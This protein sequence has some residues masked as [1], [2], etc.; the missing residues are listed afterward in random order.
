MSRTKVGVDDF[1]DQA[2]LYSKS[3]AQAQNEIL[4]NE[5]AISQ[6]GNMSPTQD[7]YDTADELITS[8]KEQLD[9]LAAKSIEM[10]TAYDD[11]TRGDFLVLTTPEFFAFQK[12][13]IVKSVMLLLGAFCALCMFVVTFPEKKL[14]SGTE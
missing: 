9:G 10:V 7:M 1:A 13:Y 2:E 8:A 12:S 14:A 11:E 5:Y 3:A 6:F 4:D